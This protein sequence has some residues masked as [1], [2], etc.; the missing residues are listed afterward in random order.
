LLE[1][2]AHCHPQQLKK[3]NKTL[4]TTLITDKDNA[5]ILEKISIWENKVN[6]NDVF[7]QYISSMWEVI[8]QLLT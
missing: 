5:Q 8:I 3:Y 2:V 4:S 6:F 7:H 1:S